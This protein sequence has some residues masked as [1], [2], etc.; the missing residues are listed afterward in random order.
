MPYP[1]DNNLALTAQFN[2]VF[3]SAHSTNALPTDLR[4]FQA[5][6][7]GSKFW[8]VDGNEYID[9]TGA[10]GPGI[11]GHCHPEYIRSLQQYIETQPVC[12]GA[13]YIYSENDILLAEKIIEHVPCAEQVKLCVSGSEAVQQAIRLARAYTGRPYFLKFSGHYHGWIDNIYGGTV[14]PHP[15]GK[16]FPVFEKESCLGQSPSSKTEGLMVPWGNIEQLELTLSRYGN[17]IAVIILEAVCSAGTLLPPPGFLKNIRRLC[18]H[19]NVVLCFDEIITGFRTG[20]QGAQGLYGV[21]PDICT[22]GKALGG[23][24]PISAVTGRADI[25]GQFTD[26]KVNG[27][28]TFNGNPLCVRGALT[29]LQVL[30]RDEGVAYIE[31]A[32]IQNKLMQGLD[33]VAR[34]RGVPMRVQ[35]PAGVFMTFFGVDPDRPLFTD[36]DVRGTDIELTIKVYK[37]LV[38]AGVFTLCGRWFPSIVHTQQDNTQVLEAFDNVLACL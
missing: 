14:D 28:G 32:D 23:G 16:P 37:L 27:G 38:E 36:Q 6:A 11:L 12:S 13:S 34:R 5:K 19:Y 4:I 15:K 26:G 25:L 10:L 33:E 18:D 31:M 17:D 30:E 2:H 3:P 20:L 7:K 22:L 8:D 24:L 1:I 9:Y 29:T 35:G 21:T